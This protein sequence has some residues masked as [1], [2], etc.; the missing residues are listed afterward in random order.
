[1]RQIGI[2]WSMKRVV[3]ALP[4]VSRGTARPGFIRWHVRSAVVIWL[5]C[6]S[7]PFHLAHYK[8]SLYANGTFRPI[9]WLPWP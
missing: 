6:V 7:S 9:Q 4:D 2:F 3:L 1:M 5:L 8:P